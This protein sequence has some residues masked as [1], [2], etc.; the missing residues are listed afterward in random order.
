MTRRAECDKRDIDG[1]SVLLAPDN[2]S[3]VSLIYVSLTSFDID[4]HRSSSQHFL[5]LAFFADDEKMKKKLLSHPDAQH[6][7][8]ADH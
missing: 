2:V 1:L 4:K 8:S 7:A 3:R 6:L 5:L